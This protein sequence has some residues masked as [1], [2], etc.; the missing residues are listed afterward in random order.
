VI[1]RPLPTR[2][3]GIGL[4]L[5]PILAVSCRSPEPQGE[6]LLGDPHEQ[7]QEVERQ[8]RGFD[9]AM[10]EVGYRF[11]E[12]YFA[13]QDRNYPYARYQLE[14]MELAIEL[15]LERR[16]ARAAS[17][18]PFLEEALPPVRAAIE[19]EDPNQF[20]EGFETLR[21][22]CMLC[23]VQEEVPHFAVQIPQNRQSP[24]RLGP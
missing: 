12:L 15:G 4:F 7:L 18:R 16:P 9:M 3:L 6:W 24:I 2:P 21:A 13:G 10:V 11:T 8:L 14:K 20:E 17:A 5:I 19:A 23:H 22:G 1:S